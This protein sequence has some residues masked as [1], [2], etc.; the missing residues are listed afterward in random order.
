MHIPPCNSNSKYRYGSPSCRSYTKPIISI[1]ED[2]SGG[3]HFTIKQACYCKIREVIGSLKLKGGTCEV[4]CTHP[5]FKENNPIKEI[6]RGSNLSYLNIESDVIQSLDLLYIESTIEYPYED[7]TIDIKIIFDQFPTQKFIFSY[8]EVAPLVHLLRS[9][10]IDET[11]EDFMLPTYSNPTCALRLSK[12]ASSSIIDSLLKDLEDGIKTRNLE[13]IQ[14]IRNSK[15]VHDIGKDSFFDELV[16][17]IKT[18]NSEEIMAFNRCEMKCGMCF[19]DQDVVG[20]SNGEEHFGLYYSFEAKDAIE[21]YACNYP[22]KADK[23]EPINFNRLTLAFENIIL[24]IEL[25]DKDLVSQQI[26]LGATV[27]RRVVDEYFNDC[28]DP[29][30]FDYEKGIDFLLLH[31]MDKYQFQIATLEE[32]GAPLNKHLSNFPIVYGEDEDGNKCYWI[33]DFDGRLITGFDIYIYT[34][35]RE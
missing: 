34:L 35:P 30:E 5:V 15:F 16:D 25:E 20:F 11:L 6:G 33:V 17:K 18:W 32:L 28:I 29:L 26:K 23:K 4:E 22:I 13:K 21:I 10:N 7:E 1:D 31:M 2:I 27:T 19:K 14:E 24:G 9:L 12:Y 8:P 3:Y